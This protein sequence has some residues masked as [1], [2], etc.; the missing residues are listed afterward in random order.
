[1]K[2]VEE[3]MAPVPDVMESVIVPVE[4]ETPAPAEFESKVENKPELVDT[5]PPIAEPVDVGPTDS[6]DVKPVVSHEI[7]SS[8]H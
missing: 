6:K 5:E 1:M 2:D 4:E 7:G 8:S 3:T